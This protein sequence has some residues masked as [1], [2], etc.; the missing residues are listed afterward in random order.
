MTSAPKPDTDDTAFRLGPLAVVVAGIVAFGPLMNMFWRFAI[1]MSWHSPRLSGLLLGPGFL[2][3]VAT[4][5]CVVVV[6][7]VL[8]AREGRKQR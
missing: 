4:Y 7:A 1:A 8:M 5:L 3:V 2:V 6:G